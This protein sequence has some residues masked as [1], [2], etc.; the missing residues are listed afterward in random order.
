MKNLIKPIGS[1]LL[2]ALILVGAYTGYQAVE[3]YMDSRI[4]V[5][6]GRYEAI[7]T[8]YSDY[9]KE[10]KGRLETMSLE[11][12]RLQ[13]DKLKLVRVVDEQTV[14]IR[15]IRGTIT[16]LEAA[17]VVLTD[18]N[19]KYDNAMAQIFEYKK[20]V[21]VYEQRFITC[22]ATILTQEEII[23]RCVA[24]AQ[25]FEQLY[26]HEETLKKMVESRLSLSE[27][28]LLWEKT[29]FKGSTVLLLAVG[30]FVLYNEVTK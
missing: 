1:I 22:K 20:V 13:Q 6:R 27:K 30:G 12:Q 14:V 7:S 29:K 23:K 8:Q 9:K 11:V 24:T 18:I 3:K 19:A 25:E 2:A 4:S 15:S 26:L 28:R 10:A 16:D 21:N 17:A 5:E